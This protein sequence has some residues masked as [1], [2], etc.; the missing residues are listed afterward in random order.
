MNNT[1]PKSIIESG[2]LINPVH[3][4]D[5]AICLPALILTGIALIKRKNVGF[6]MASTM[7]IFCIFMS[8]AIAAMVFVMKSR[9][10][11]ADL[12]LTVIFGIITVI[13][14]VFLVQYLRKLK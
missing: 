13:S 8:V 1:T 6:L 7:L 14:T 12:N 4:L 10:M 5:I 9:G 11:E 2:L 3:V